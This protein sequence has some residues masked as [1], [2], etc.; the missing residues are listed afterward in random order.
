MVSP[1]AIFTNTSGSVMV[2]RTY[3]NLQFISKN[4]VN[5][6]YQYLKGVT[7][8]PW[9]WGYHSPSGTIV[10]S[11]YNPEKTRIDPYDQWYLSGQAT[12]FHF[13][14]K[15]YVKATEGINIYDDNQKLVF[16]SNIQPMRVVDFIQGK[17]DVNEIV[18]GKVIYDKLFKPNRIYAVILGQYSYRYYAGSSTL[19]CFAPKIT[20]TVSTGRV[21]IEFAI[22]GTAS[23]GS[24]RGNMYTND[25]NFLV[26]DVTNY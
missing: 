14:T 22:A 5:A 3:N 8:K 18:N 16:S 7:A 13:G 6:G 9:L 21:K 25:Y 2:D 4:S 26:V 20:T 11:A 24:Y 1:K 12:L 15:E 19:Y 23:A 17:F 10:C